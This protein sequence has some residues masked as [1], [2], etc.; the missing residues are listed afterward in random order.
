MIINKPI[1]Y[2]LA[3]RSEIKRLIE[4][5]RFP[6]PEFYFGLELYQAIIWFLKYRSIMTFREA[7][8]NYMELTALA[9]TL[10]DIFDTNKNVEML[11]REIKKEDIY[12]TK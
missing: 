6:N 2:K 1:E 9:K 7:M 12:D 10:D 3:S 4:E 11:S 5:E 8:E